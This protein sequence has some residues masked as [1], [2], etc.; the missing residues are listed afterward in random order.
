MPATRRE[1]RRLF[2]P[3][4]NITIQTGWTVASVRAALQAHE[5]ADFTSS[6]LLIDMMGR[7]DRLG[8]TSTGVIGSRANGLLGRPFCLR[9]ADPDDP[10]AVRAADEI[11]ELWWSML[12]ESTLRVVLRSLWM[13]G[14]S[15]CELRWKKYA[16]SQGD[17]WAPCVRPWQ[18]HHMYMVESADDNQLTNIWRLMTRDGNVEITPGDGK[19]MLVADGEQWW[20]NG[21]VRSLAVPWLAKQ[22]ALRDWLRHSERLGQPIIKAKHPADWDD[23]EV[24]DWFEGLVALATETTTKLPQQGDGVGFDL[25][26]L[27]ASGENWQSFQGLISHINTLYAVHVLGHNLTTEVEGGSYAAALVGDEVRIDFMR[28]DAEN[29]SSHLRTQMLSHICAEWYGRP[30]LAPWPEWEVDPPEHR[31]QIADTSKAI[32]EALQAL[33]AAGYEPADVG[34]WS[35]AAGVELRPMSSQS[36][37]PSSPPQSTPTEPPESD[38][39]EPD[40]GD[41]AQLHLASGDPLELAQGLVGAQQTADEVADEGIARAQRAMAPDIASVLSVVD[42]VLEKGGDVQAMRVQLLELYR[43]MSPAK[44]AELLEKAEVLAEMRGMIS[45]LE[46]L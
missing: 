7:D 36:S 5:Q 11:E 46:D 24:E 4:S 30:E 18:L 37:P 44:L 10:A 38:P 40:D 20:L 27:E 8:M 42:S 28:S 45:V 32:G 1:K 9:P 22:F 2:S 13:A 26:L 15:P 39:G 12:P 33:H 23:T 14:G 6:G 3:W 34:Q 31:K 17:R 16:H 29:L 21:S 43:T 35:I 25:E 19:W 41:E